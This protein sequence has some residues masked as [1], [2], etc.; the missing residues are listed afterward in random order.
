[1]PPAPADETL[2]HGIMRMLRY[3]FEPWERH[4]SMLEAYYL[5]RTGQAAQRLD[6]QGFD[7]ILPAASDLLARLDPEYVADIGLVLTNMVHS[8]IGRFAAGA[9][10]I[11][12]ILPAL[13]RIVYRLT[14]NN[15]P[16]AAPAQAQRQN[17]A[18][19]T[20]VLRPS[21]ISPYDP[22]P[23]TTSGT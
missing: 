17:G 19:Q 22:G 18:A 23:G 7:A 1:M 20:L 4:P 9:I 2:R 21:F 3:V 15:E 11:T 8:L 5:T 16:F 10:E 14:T 6:A 12:D 13:D